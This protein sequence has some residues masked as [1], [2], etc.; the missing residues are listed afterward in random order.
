LQG[1]S[2]QFCDYGPKKVLNQ[3]IELIHDLEPIEVAQSEAEKFKYEHGDRCDVCTGDGDQWFVKFKKG[4]RVVVP[5][6]FTFSCLVAGQISIGWD[7]DR[8]GIPRDVIAQTDRAALRAL[9]CETL[10]ASGPMNYTS[11]ST[12]LT[13]ALASVVV[14]VARK[15]L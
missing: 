10:N 2:E 7:P 5:K 9:F 13:L 3:E 6:A 4:A 15:V 1:P 11:T 14:W 8:Y 12:P